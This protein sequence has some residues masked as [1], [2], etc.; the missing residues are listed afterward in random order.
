MPVIQDFR[1]VDDFYL[2]EAYQGI[3]NGRTIE[4]FRI[5][6]NFYLY[7]VILGFVIIDGVTSE[8][9]I[10]AT[11]ATQA[12]ARLLTEDINRIDTVGANTG[13][14]LQPY[15][16]NLRRTILNNGISD[17][18]VYP[19]LGQNFLGS[20]VNVPVVLASGSSL[21]AFC[22]EAEAGVWTLIS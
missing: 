3:N 10:T 18:N 15:V 11:G 22:F 14:R 12:T 9:G 6:D 8:M 20:A 1:I 7:Q 5:V 17:L 4:Q 19:A 13:V 2:W 21:E 16:E